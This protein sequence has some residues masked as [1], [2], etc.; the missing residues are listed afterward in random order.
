MFIECP[1]CG[2]GSTSKELNCTYTCGFLASPH[3]PELYPDSTTVTWNIQIKEDNY[4]HLEFID[5]HVESARRECEQDF[6]E[7]YNIL[8][9]GTKGLIGRYCIPTPPP[10]VLL[11]HMNQMTL[12]FRSDKQFANTGFLAQYQ[13]KQYTLPDHIKMKINN[14]GKHLSYDIMVLPRIDDT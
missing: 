4:I 11:S 10:A 13:S 6:V 14:N 3:Y 5:F 7:I 1:G 9:D 12:I 8:K 2:V